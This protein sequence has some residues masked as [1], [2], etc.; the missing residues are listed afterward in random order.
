MQN[1][2]GH[3]TGIFGN[4]ERVKPGIVRALAPKNSGGG[5]GQFIELRIGMLRQGG[6]SDGRDDHPWHAHFLQAGLVVGV[7]R[8]AVSLRTAFIFFGSG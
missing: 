7:F 5:G 8:A 1:D 2:K 4:P 6:F 3:A